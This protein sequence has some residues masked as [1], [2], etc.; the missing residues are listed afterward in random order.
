MYADLRAGRLADCWA[1]PS[2]LERHG[3]LIADDWMV[4]ARIEQLQ[5]RPDH[6]LDSL[7][8]VDIEI[9][10]RRKPG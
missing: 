1:A 5:G 7:R 10:S 8:G 2:W 4:R 3:P 6:A 9:R